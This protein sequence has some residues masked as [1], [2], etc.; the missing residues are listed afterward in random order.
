MLFKDF[1]VGKTC[2]NETLVKFII[3]FMLQNFHFTL[4]LMKKVKPQFLPYKLGL[5]CI[6]C[7][8]IV[9]FVFFCC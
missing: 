7:N 2:L 1:F 3:V 6:C 9:T 5:N 8:L 4:I